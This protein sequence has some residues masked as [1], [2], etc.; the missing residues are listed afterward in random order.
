MRKSK[1]PQRELFLQDAP[2][3]A[4]PPTQKAQLAKLVEVL[5][6]EIAAALAAGEAGDDQDHG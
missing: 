2:H 3:V 5:L 1:N 6:R 4:L